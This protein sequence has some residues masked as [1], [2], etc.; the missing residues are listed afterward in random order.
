MNKTIAQKGTN[1]QRV[2]LLCPR[3]RKTCGPEL[4]TILHYQL[5]L[6][7][8]LKKA[9]V[10]TGKPNGG[11][12]PAG[13]YTGI[14]EMTDATRDSCLANGEHFGLWSWEDDVVKI[15]PRFKERNEDISTIDFWQLS[16]D[17]IR[18]HYLEQTVSKYVADS[19]PIDEFARQHPDLFIPQHQASKIGPGKGGPQ[20]FR[21]LT[22]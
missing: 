11:I 7:E 12:A 6:V 15:S 2:F 17:M 16:D 10:P 20:R 18:I 3:D 22:T 13:Y 8:E 4:G 9:G 21:Q 14:L 19:T 1:V 5:K